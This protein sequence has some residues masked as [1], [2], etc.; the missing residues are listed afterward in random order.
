MVIANIIIH[1]FKYVVNVGLRRNFAKGRHKSQPS[2]K[3]S[4][5]IIVGIDKTFFECN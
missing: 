5:L 1:Y 4:L 3:T 2:M